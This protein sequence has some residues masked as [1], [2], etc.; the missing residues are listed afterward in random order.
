MKENR[1][2]TTRLLPVT[3]TPIEIDERAHALA[4]SAAQ[5]AR[6][7]KSAKLAAADWK[8]RISEEKE[9]STKLMNAVNNGVEDREVQCEIRIV[10]NV[11][12]VVRLDTLETVDARPATKEELRSRDYRTTIFDHGADAPAQ[13][14]APEP[15]P[16]ATA[17]EVIEAEV[18]E[19]TSA[20][21]AIEAKGTLGEIIEASDANPDTTDEDADLVKLEEVA[22][23]VS[24]KLLETIRAGAA[25]NGDGTGGTVFRHGG[26][27]Y[28][29]ET[30]DEDGNVDA[31][32]VKTI[33]MYPGERKRFYRFALSFEGSV[34]E[35]THGE[36]WVIIADTVY[37]VTTEIKAEAA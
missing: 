27:H 14:A 30:L 24:P 3:L 12:E 29:I 7:E 4:K 36:K 6:L 20:P 1:T 11:Y 31:W 15:Q 34:V 37:N 13:P 32:R 19:S 2:K 28:I 10:G 35:D 8:E 26:S 5:V 9:V 25:L 21:L 16:E 33:G 17:A 22:L 18:I 23:R